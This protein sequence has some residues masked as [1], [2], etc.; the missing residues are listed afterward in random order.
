LGSCAQGSEFANHVRPAH[1]L[2]SVSLATQE[3]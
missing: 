2:P 3:W 1:H